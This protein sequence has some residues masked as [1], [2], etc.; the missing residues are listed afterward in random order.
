M[1]SELTTRDSRLTTGPILHPLEDLIVLSVHAEPGVDLLG[2]RVTPV[3]IQADTTNAIIGS[4]Q[5]LKVGVES[6]INSLTTTLRDHIDALNP[7]HDAVAPVAPLIRD[8]SRSDNVAGRLT[9]VIAS[10]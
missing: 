6:G 10:Q 4:R 3:D 9:D 2:N 1:S 5:I 7:P 8:Q